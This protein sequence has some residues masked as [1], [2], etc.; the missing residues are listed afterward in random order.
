MHVKLEAVPKE[1]TE[2]TQRVTLWKDR[3]RHSKGTPI[4]KGIDAL[5][6]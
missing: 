5:G 3:S 4:P 2:I 6:Y 1:Q